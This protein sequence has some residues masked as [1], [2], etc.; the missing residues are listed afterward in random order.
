M[1]EAGGDHQFNQYRL[2]SP[3]NRPAMPLC[4][5]S[6]ACRKRAH[7]VLRAGQQLPEMLSLMHH[8]MIHEEDMQGLA[9]DCR[10]TIVQIPGRVGIYRRSGQETPFAG[11]G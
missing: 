9:A 11:R 7:L 4:M 8:E 10:E 2:V 3:F 6:Q 5:C 1:S